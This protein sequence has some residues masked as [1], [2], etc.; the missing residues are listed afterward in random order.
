MFGRNILLGGRDRMDHCSGGHPGG[1]GGGGGGECGRGS[2]AADQGAVPAGA[3]FLLSSLCSH[4]L[5][6]SVQHERAGDNQGGSDLF[7][8]SL[9]PILAYTVFPLPRPNNLASPFFVSHPLLLTSDPLV[10]F[11]SSTTASGD[12]AA[13]GQ[14]I[15]RFLQ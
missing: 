13:A 15:L 4:T 8:R 5:I 1:G 12:G 7:P 3:G 2:A 11:L 14:E 9:P 6:A 10:R